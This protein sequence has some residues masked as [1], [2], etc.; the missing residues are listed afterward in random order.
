MD[1]STPST[2]VGGDTSYLAR[3]TRYYGHVSLTSRSKSRRVHSVNKGDIATSLEEGTQLME[4]SANQS[5]AAEA[6]IAA[7]SSGVEGVRGH[8]V[9][10]QETSNN[11]TTIVTDLE[12]TGI[13][14]TVGRGRAG[15]EGDTETAK[16]LV[17]LNPKLQ[18]H[19]FQR[20]D[21]VFE[22]SKGAHA[23]DWQIPAT[24][25]ASTVSV[26]AVVPLIG[27]SPYLPEVPPPHTAI[28]NNGFFWTIPI[29]LTIPLR[30][31]TSLCMR[32]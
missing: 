18:Q 9:V 26:T 31:D 6:D 25:A 15:T 5:T 24:V 19:Q 12:Q 23:C 20:P 28:P 30:V 17:P 13:G 27:A 16:K 21:S 4:R 1:L 8:L 11:M 7:V 2:L 32:S 22:F 3:M 14:P 10:I 29:C